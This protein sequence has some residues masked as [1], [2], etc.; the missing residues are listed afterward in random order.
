MRG[1]KV[2]AFDFL[3]K[4]WIYGKDLCLRTHDDGTLYAAMYDSAGGE[5]HIRLYECIGLQDK[6]GVDVYESDHLYLDD[7]L[8]G[9]VVFDN[10]SFGLFHPSNQQGRNILNS[11]RMRFL[12]ARGNDYENP[13]LLKESA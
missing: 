12:E 7:D 9:R 2:R 13:E 6:N 3:R 1:L 10:G 5:V 8:V 4:K 11:E